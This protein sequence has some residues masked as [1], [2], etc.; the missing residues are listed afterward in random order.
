MKRKIKKRNLHDLSGLFIFA[1]RKLKKKVPLKR[2]LPYNR[3]RRASKTKIN[4]DEV[5]FPAK[6]HFLKGFQGSKTS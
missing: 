2:I 3:N 4:C 5:T 1:Y 6:L